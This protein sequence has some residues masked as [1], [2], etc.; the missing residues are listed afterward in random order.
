V[1]GG[2]GKE[3]VH[4]DLAQTLNEAETETEIENVASCNLVHATLFCLSVW[5][6]P[7]NE[8]S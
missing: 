5:Q 8:L 6:W 4:L 1:R 7:D 3:V 2:T